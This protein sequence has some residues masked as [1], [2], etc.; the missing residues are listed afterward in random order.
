MHY[1]LCIKSEYII[2]WLIDWLIVKLWLLKN[3][4]RL[5]AVDLSRKKE[6]DAT[7]QIEFI[8]QL[9]KLDANNNNDQCMFV[10]TILEKIK[11]ITVL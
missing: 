1:V 6:L 9:R 3:H 2:D 10:L 7:Q 4:Y 8:G 5:I 11:E